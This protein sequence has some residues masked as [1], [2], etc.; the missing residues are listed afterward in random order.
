MSARLSP[1][2]SC[3]DDSQEDN[4]Q[5]LPLITRESLPKSPHLANAHRV[6]GPVVHYRVLAFPLPTDAQLKWVENNQ[7]G[8]GRKPHMRRLLA[9]P[10]IL[11]RLTP[12]CR[13]LA[14]VVLDTGAP[15][16]SVVVATN[17]TPE[18]LARAEDLE[19]IQ[20]VQRVAGATEPPAWYR[21]QRAW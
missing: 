3:R 18:D 11:H 1:L 16:Y 6:N 19:M 17:K 20:S 21:P 2:I 10:A 7:L 5:N 15:C 9:L 12:D 4:D 13:R 8:V 14:I